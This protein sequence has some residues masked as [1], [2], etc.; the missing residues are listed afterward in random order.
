MYRFS[1]SILLFVFVFV[2][3]TL[4]VA[5]DTPIF[6]GNVE[7][8]FIGPDI[9]IIEDPEQIDVAMPSDFPTGTISGNDIKDVRFFYDADEDILYVGINT[10]LIAGDVDGND[11]PGGT[12]FFLD[13]LGGVDLPDFSG[14]ESF[15]LSIDIDEDGVFDVIA[16]VSAAT[17]TSG[18]SVNLFTGSPHVPEFAFGQPL[19]VNRGTLFASP[20]ANAPDLEFSILDFSTLPFSSAMDPTPHRVGI[21]VFMGSFADIGIGE[22]FLPDVTE[23]FDL[24]IASGIEITKMP[25][26]STVEEGGT[27][28]FDVTVSNGGNS[29][30]NN[31]IVTDEISPDCAMNIQDLAPG[32]NATYRCELDDIRS[33][34]TTTIVVEAVDPQDNLV[35]AQSE[36]AI[37]LATQSYF[38]ETTINGENANS[39][40]NAFQA[41]AEDTL[42]VEYTLHNTGNT[43]IEWVE[44][45]D[46]IFGS[47]NE[48]LLVS[49]IGSG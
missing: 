18:Y 19:V 27:A 5:A 44:L 38:L 17:D 33:E 7:T 3:Y 10:Y 9:V 32:E 20:S 43:S 45:R 37:V 2:I 22:D 21:N 12:G 15:A 24:P 23:I 31:I 28:Q 14:T 42:I 26:E 4:P 13:D 34:I 39:L 47:L 6:S 36:A 30:L 40:A 29:P 48:C 35:T 46:S 11:N 41:A 1:K 8:D 49:D 25:K 16:G